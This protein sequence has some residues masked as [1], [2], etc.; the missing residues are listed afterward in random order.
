MCLWYFGAIII[1]NVKLVFP[2]D[3]KHQNLFQYHTALIESIE[4]IFIDYNQHSQEKLTQY[5]II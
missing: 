5:I 2:P 4:K 3:C 1:C